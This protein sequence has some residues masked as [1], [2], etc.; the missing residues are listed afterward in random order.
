MQRILKD[1]GINCLLRAFLKK[2]I[3][4]IYK[5]QYRNTFLASR[6]ANETGK[7]VYRMNALGLLKSYTKDYN[8]GFYKCKFY[9]G[10]SIDYYVDNLS[11]YL[12]RYQSEI[13]VKGKLKKSEKVFLKNRKI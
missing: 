6:D 4:L 5:S 8:K 7:M 12:R 1:F 11:K 10:S 3:Y 2:K 9:K 13:T